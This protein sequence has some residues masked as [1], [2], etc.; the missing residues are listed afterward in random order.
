MSKLSKFKCRNYCTK[1][2]KKWEKGVWAQFLCLDELHK[3]KK[4]KKTDVPTT[5]LNLIFRLGKHFCWGNKN[6]LH[7]LQKIMVLTVEDWK[8]YDEETNFY[9][10]GQSSNDKIFWSHS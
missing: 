8:N 5:T 1:R 2:S 4:Q 10:Q 6:E 9:K 3:E 7:P